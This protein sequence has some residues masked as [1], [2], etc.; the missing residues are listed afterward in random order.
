MI[1]Q[2]S[3]SPIVGYRYVLLLFYLI[4]WGGCFDLVWFSFIFLSSKSHVLS[5]EFTFKFQ[6]L[7]LNLDPEVICLDII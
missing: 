1:F 5:L 4:F 3:L 2:K 7:I 6:R